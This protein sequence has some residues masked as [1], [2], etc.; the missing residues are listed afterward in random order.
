MTKAVITLTRD[1][2]EEAV[3]EYI[4]DRVRAGYRFKTS[5]ATLG[6]DN[7]DGAVGY[8]ECSVAMDIEPEEQ[9]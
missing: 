3:K 9:A 7:K 4:A 6:F 5:E 2:V 1:E 8:F